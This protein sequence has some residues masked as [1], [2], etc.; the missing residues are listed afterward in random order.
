MLTQSQRLEWSMTFF[1]K[2]NMTVL[3]L[4]LLHKIFTSSLNIH[5]HTCTNT[6]IA[7]RCLKG[8]EHQTLNPRKLLLFSWS[9]CTYFLS[10]HMLKSCLL[11]QVL[12][13]NFYMSNSQSAMY[14]SEVC[15]H[16]PYSLHVGVSR[17]H[18]SIN[19]LVFPHSVQELQWETKRKLYM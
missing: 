9:Y 2:K 5:I 7:F 12:I 16:L 8:T 1:W 13:L 15:T 18:F 10:S 4:L 6:Y 17:L 3:E 11:I 14:L 19:F